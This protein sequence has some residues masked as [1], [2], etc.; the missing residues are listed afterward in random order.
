MLQLAFPLA[1]EFSHIDLR[2]TKIPNLLLK[3]PELLFGEGEDP[4][5]RD[6]SIVTDANNLRYLAE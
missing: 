1:D 6:T 3:E 2:P 5:A 4:M